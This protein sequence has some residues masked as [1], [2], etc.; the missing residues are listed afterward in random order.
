MSIF[1]KIKKVAESTAS[2]IGNKKE[3]FTFPALPESLAEMQ[4]LPEASL[5]GSIQNGGSYSLRN[6]CLRSRQEYWNRNA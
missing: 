2:S 6:L 1:D 5:D 3:T 4:S